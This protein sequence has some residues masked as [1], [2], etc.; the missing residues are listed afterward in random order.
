MNINNNQNKNQNNNNI[1]ENKSIFTD[2]MGLL[3]GVSSPLA[4]PTSNGPFIMN[5][6]NNNNNNDNNNND[7]NSSNLVPTSIN[8]NN[9]LHLGQNN[10]EKGAEQEKDDKNASNGSFETD[11]SFLTEEQPAPFFDVYQQPDQ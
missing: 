10:D 9:Q 3:G 5:N 1:V 8:Q 2:S 4:S 11:Y 7:N 6:N